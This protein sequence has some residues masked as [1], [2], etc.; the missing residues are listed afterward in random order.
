[1][2]ITEIYDKYNLPPNL[3]DHHFRVAAVS[4]TVVNNWA[5]PKINCELI[6]RVCLIHDLGNLIKY[7]LNG[8]LNKDMDKEFWSKIQGGL[9]DKYGLNEQEA[10]VLMAKE[11]VADSNV[12]DTLYLLTSNM[13]DEIAASGNWELK[14]C[15]Y[16][17]V[18]VGPFGVV[19]LTERMAEWKER[20]KNRVGWEKEKK[21]YNE[22]SQACVNIEDQ[23]SQ[24]M[25]MSINQIS[26]HSISKYLADLPNSQI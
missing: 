14:I 2:V 1:M 11:F 9:I 18:R 22:I 6:K 26:N 17:D 13:A 21:R 10:T 20:Y 7:D 16:G 5:G 25:K 23:I 15:L 19:S 24:K 3:K 12:L 4:L 8:D